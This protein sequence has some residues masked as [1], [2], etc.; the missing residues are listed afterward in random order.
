MSTE[1]GLEAALDR[2]RRLGGNELLL[3]MLELYVSGSARQ[4]ESMQ[5]AWQARDLETIGAAAHSLRTSAGN[6]GLD[7]LSSLATSLEEGIRGGRAD[8][9]ES[10]L[11]QLVVA[12]RN[13]LERIRQLRQHPG[14][15]P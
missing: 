3:R 14:A 6:L 9:L 2:L 15:N 8:G 12:H 10:L 1:S 13:S 7:R 5:A 11:E 4:V